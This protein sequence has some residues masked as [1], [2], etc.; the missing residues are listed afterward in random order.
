MIGGVPTREF[1]EPSVAVIFLLRFFGG[2]VTVQRTRRHLTLRAKTP[3]VISMVLSRASP[4]ESRQE[5]SN[6]GRQNGT[7]G[8]GGSPGVLFQRSRSAPF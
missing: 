1:V 7:V 4:N 2:I 3:N 8:K 6:N 5:V